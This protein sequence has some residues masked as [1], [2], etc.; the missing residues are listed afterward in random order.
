MA[1]WDLK[2]L[3]LA[4]HVASWSKDPSTQCG[5]VVV[6]ANDP[7]KIALGYN[8]FPP[9]IAD[10]KERLLDRATKYSLMVH[11]ERN[12]LANATFDCTGGTIYCTHPCLDCAKSIISKRIKRVVCPTPPP[13]EDGRWTAE[14]PRAR[15]LLDEAGVKVTVVSE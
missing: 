7:R 5:A 9:G 4:Q 10:T 8:G 6:A 2:F 13:A 3:R 14:I 12:A 11:A 1:N 15:A